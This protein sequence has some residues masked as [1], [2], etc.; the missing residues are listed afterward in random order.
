MELNR[1][2]FIKNLS[3]LLFSI[4]TSNCAKD[5]ITGEKV[6]SFLDKNDE[7]KID[8]ENAKFQF[9]ADYGKVQD[10]KLNSY[11]ESVGIKL[12]KFSHRPDM[13]Y[14]FRVVNA[15]YV[16]AYT[17]PAGS[18]AITRGMIINLNSEAEL[19]AVLGHEIGHVSARHTAKRMSKAVLI[20]GI[21][22]GLMIYLNVENNPFVPVVSSA[23]SLGSSILLASYSRKDELQ[24]DALGLEY[25]INAGYSP[26]GMLEL[27][28]MLMSLEKDEPSLLEV[29]FSTH[30]M[31]EER[32]NNVKDIISKKY[33]NKREYVIGRERFMDN[34]ASLRKIKEAI[35]LLQKAAKF[36]S[37]NKYV[38]SKKYIKKAL[39]IAPDDYV[40]LVFMAICN[41]HLN[42]YDEALKYTNLA[43][44]VYP[45]EGQAHF[46]K[47][48]ILIK[49]EK[50][51]ESL[52][53]FDK[54]N[55]ILPGNPEILFY[56]GYCFD[57]M[58]R[59]DE[60]IN[61]YLS[62]LKKVDR[63]ENAD[64]ARK[65]LQYLRYKKIFS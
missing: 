48:L 54:Y 65:R 60:A 49:L 53:S 5:P 19:A 10:I 17:F 39:N 36:M 7:I 64:Y 22:T 9:S 4:C 3:I 6:F 12:A 38:E 29:M 15:V 44:D 41:Y 23:A 34:T 55:E 20:S 28:N 1:R 27:F 50:Y 43:E 59:Y 37:S 35:M 26:E 18:V 56:K 47:G 21:L 57:K 14:S 42:S 30:P 8:K 46:L 25:M 63:G 45:D 16:N 62:Y 52:K 2:E 24:A 13:P 61:Y 11:I 58:G 32:Y 40:G 31:S 51:E 33:N